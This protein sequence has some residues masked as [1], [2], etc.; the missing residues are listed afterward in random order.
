MTDEKVFEVGI[1]TAL[2]KGVHRFGRFLANDR[3][4][5]SKALTKDGR[6]AFCKSVVNRNQI[7]RYS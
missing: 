4:D 7:L 6:L 5:R 2:W 1:A 3:D